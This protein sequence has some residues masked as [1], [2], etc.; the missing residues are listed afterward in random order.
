MRSMKSAGEVISD[1]PIRNLEGLGRLQY[2]L[3]KSLFE[4]KWLTS[5]YVGT[6]FC[7]R[8][9]GVWTYYAQKI[10]KYVLN[11]RGGRKNTS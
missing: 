7:I 10:A 6:D 9:Q 5:R 4:T 3:G 1:A 11:P 2:L 8:V